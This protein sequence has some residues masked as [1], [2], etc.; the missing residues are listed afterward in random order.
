MRKTNCYAEDRR[1]SPAGGV[2][3]RQMRR[4]AYNL[5]EPSPDWRCIARYLRHLLFLFRGSRLYL[6]RIYCSFLF[7]SLIFC[8][9]GPFDARST[10]AQIPRK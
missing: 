3:L 5:V 7:A 6:T 8:G 10:S 1:K 2:F 9:R 4:E